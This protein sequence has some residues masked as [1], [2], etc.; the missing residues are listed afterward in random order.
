VTY[1]AAPADRAAAVSR[2]DLTLGRT[3]ILAA[4]GAVLWFMAAMFIR[5]VGP[6]GAFHGIWV[7]I[8]YALAAPV[9]APAILLGPRA[10]G[11]PRERVLTSV[12]VMSVTALFLDGVCLA[13][14]RGLYGTDPVVILG[15]AAWLLWAVG[16][17]LALALSV[18]RRP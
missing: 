18:R 1:S 4:I 9:L 8:L 3:V 10:A 2:G 16:A 11:L 17:A 13:W 14:F 5:F 6:L 15:G 7:P 12:S